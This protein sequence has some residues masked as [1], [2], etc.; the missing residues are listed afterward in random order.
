MQK[1]ELQGTQFFKN[2]KAPFNFL[3]FHWNKNIVIELTNP[4]TVIY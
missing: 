3:D 1:R 2:H 4:T